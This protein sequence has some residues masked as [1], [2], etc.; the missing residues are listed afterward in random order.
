MSMLIAF[1]KAANAQTQ[2]CYEDTTI[3]AHMICDGNVGSSVDFTTGC[4]DIP[5]T[6][7][8]T[9]VACPPE[10]EWVNVNMSSRTLAGTHT[11]GIPAGRYMRS[12]ITLTLRHYSLPTH[13]QICASAGMVPSDING[14]VCASGKNRPITGNNFQNINYWWGTIG[15]AGSGGTIVQ[16]TN[17]TAGLPN[18]LGAPWFEST[19]ACWR[20]ASAIVAENDFLSTPAF[21]YLNRP[22][23]Y[24]TDIAVAFACIEP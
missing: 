18:M 3:P 5:E 13:S 9:P 8:Q 21:N 15:A 11:G 4:R 22:L 24:Y 2:T 10:A 17:H 20:N 1:D 6:V 23:Y 19:N 16:R 7:V 14:Q 12:R